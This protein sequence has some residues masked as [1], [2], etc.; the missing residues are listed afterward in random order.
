M[1]LIPGKLYR[2]TSVTILPVWSLDFCRTVS[3]LEKGET[4]LC[5]VVHNPEAHKISACD[6]FVAL[7]KTG[8]IGCVINRDDVEEVEC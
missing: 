1:V 7:T 5:L 3:Y 8:C 2:N 4:V 6:V